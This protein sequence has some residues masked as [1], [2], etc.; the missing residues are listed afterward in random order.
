MRHAQPLLAAPSLRGRSASLRTFPDGAGWRRPKHLILRSLLAI[1]PPISD[2]SPCSQGSGPLSEAAFEYGT[3]GCHTLRLAEP[4]C[5]SAGRFRPGAWVGGERQADQ[6]RKRMRAGLVHDGGA[7]VLDRAL[8]DAEVGGN[9][10]AGMAG[11]H[12]L[13][14]LALACG[15]TGEARRCRVPLNP[16]LGRISGRFQGALDSGE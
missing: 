11:E 16:Q 13:H 9:V 2:F 8:A 1:G 7:M 5:R 14:D 12:Q 15:Q 4:R 3:N 10:L 6:R